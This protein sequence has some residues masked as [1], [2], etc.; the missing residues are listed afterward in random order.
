MSEIISAVYEGHGLVRLEKEPEEV[1][2]HE[3]V[4]VLIVPAP[5]RK[6]LSVEE[7]G[8]QG[9]R[10][11]IQAFESR[12]SLK[13]SEFYARFLRGEMGDDRDFVV[14]AGL[15]ELL[16]RMGANTQPATTGN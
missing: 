7:V 15:Y 8:L 12:Y 2:P 5:A 6:E 11:Q 10:Q 3:H 9:L 14:W 4:T 16:Q 13:A 1:K